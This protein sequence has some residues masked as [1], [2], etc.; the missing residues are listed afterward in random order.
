MKSLRWRTAAITA[1]LRF[2]GAICVQKRA[3]LNGSRREDFPCCFIC[4]CGRSGTS[5]LGR[6]LGHHP[7]ICYLNEPRAKW[8]AVSPRTDIW[9]YSNAAAD[10]DSIMMM[11]L[12]SGEQERFRALF[13]KA[14]RGGIRFLVE[15]T[16]ENVFRLPWLH[17]LAPK[18]KLIHIR[19]NGKDVLRSILV[20][21]RLE[22]PYGLADMNNWYGTRFIKRKLLRETAISLGIDTSALNGANSADW[23]ALEWICSNRAYLKHKHLFADSGVHE[24]GY[25]DLVRTPRDTYLDL[26]KFLGLP[27]PAALMSQIMEIV[28]PPRNPAPEPILAPAMHKMFEKE[29]IRLGYI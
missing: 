20:E 9:G 16:P 8:M 7:G 18:A 1:Y 11:E 13:G 3:F 25:E 15:K 19:R 6:L 22:I 21:S 29:Q 2:Q 27:A 4:G 5:L 26:L 28:R 12:F 23:A 10:I 24:L 17:Q 14:G